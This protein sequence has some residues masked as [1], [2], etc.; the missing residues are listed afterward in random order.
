MALTMAPMYGPSP[1]AGCAKYPGQQSPA[2]GTAWGRNSKLEL[3]SP[4]DSS[5]Y[6]S[7]APSA[8]CRPSGLGFA[9]D[10]STTALA[11]YV[12]TLQ[13]ASESAH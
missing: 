5:G 8:A 6:A 1:V 7:P 4:S 3:Q 12:D 10:Y 2:K 13:Y 9:G 11:T